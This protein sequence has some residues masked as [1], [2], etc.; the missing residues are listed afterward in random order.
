VSDLVAPDSL[1]RGSS[2]Y[3][4]LSVRLWDP[5]GMDNIDSVYFWVIRPDSSSIDTVFLMN[6]DGN[7]YA[8]GDSTAN[9]SVYSC[10]TIPPGSSSQ[11]GAWTF[12]F[13]SV[14]DDGNASNVLSKSI[15][16]YDILLNNNHS[17][18]E[19]FRPQRVPNIW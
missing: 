7:L 10:L 2:D 14:D 12:Y 9:D 1:V 6:D 19:Y 8:H 5:Q 3:V 17:E 4:F 11:L 16:V 18:Q 15:I 13:K